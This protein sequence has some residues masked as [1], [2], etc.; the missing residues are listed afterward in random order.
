MSKKPLLSDSFALYEIRL[1]LLIDFNG[2]LFSAY[3]L[4]TQFPAK[5]SPCL[6]TISGCFSKYRIFNVT[7]KMYA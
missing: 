1:L 7:R 6:R 4:V 2:P 5:L 3:T